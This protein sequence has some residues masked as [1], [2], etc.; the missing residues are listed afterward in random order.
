M[1]IY[2]GRA[3]DSLPLECSSGNFT[4]ETQPT[5]AG[6]AGVTLWLMMHASTILN[7]GQGDY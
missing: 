2:E 1:Q 4:T 3:M 5:P 7:T 6:W